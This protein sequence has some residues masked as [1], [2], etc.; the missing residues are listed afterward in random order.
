M[1][2]ELQQILDK[3]PFLTFARL[4]DK[5]YL[6]IV[7]NSDTQLISMYVLDMLPQGLARKEFLKCGEEWWWGSNRQIP[8]N[9]FLKDKFKPFRICLKHF[10]KKDLEII[11]GP[12]MVSLQETIAKRTRKRQITLVQ[13]LDQ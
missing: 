2:D 7:Q 8:I 10:S 6:G 1:T 9:V 4:I 12:A 13:K 11:S 3:F 5:E